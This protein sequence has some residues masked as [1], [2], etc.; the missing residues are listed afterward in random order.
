MSFGD[1]CIDDACVLDGMRAWLLTYDCGQVSKRE[2]ENDCVAC[3][4]RT[5]YDDR[6]CPCN[7]DQ[8]CCPIQYNPTPRQSCAPVLG[9]PPGQ[10]L[11]KWF[12][13]GSKNDQ[14]WTSRCVNITISQNR[15]IADQSQM[16]NRPQLLIIS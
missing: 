2:V 13:N 14:N 1:A 10:G 9:G 3:M 6:C 8:P 15:M 11:A 16:R 12:K 4:L 7:K 5:R